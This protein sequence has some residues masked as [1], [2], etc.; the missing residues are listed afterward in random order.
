MSVQRDPFTQATSGATRFI[1]RKRTGGQVVNT[2][3]AQ[4]L[5]VL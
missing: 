1:A 2:E 5:V 4:I 3:A